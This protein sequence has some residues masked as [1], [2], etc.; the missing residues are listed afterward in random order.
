MSEQVE[1]PVAKRVPRV[2]QKHG[3]ETVDDWYWLIDREDPDTVAYLE[4]ENAFTEAGTAHLASLREQLFEEIK[5]RVQE[6]DLSVPVRDGV[7]WYVTRTV[8]GQSYPI[9]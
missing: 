5:S 2:R 9:Y 3:D 7:W 1:A 4:A 6:T 8:E